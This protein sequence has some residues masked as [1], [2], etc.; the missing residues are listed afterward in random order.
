MRRE[1]VA[2]AITLGA[3]LLATSA[4]AQDAERAEAVRWARAGDLDRAIARLRELRV[5]YP[6]NVS[7]AAD[8][9][10]VLQWAGRDREMLEVFDTIAPETAP[11]YALFAAARAARSLGE[12]ERAETYLG[13]GAE[14]FPDQNRWVV[15]RALVYADGARF[16]DAREVLTASYGTDPEDLEALL[17]W[18]YVSAASRN[19]PAALRYYTEV[20]KRQPEN[21]EALRG[22]IMA[23]EALGAPLRAE[24]LVRDSPGLLEP[25]ER[26]RVAETRSAMLLRWGKLPTGDPRTRYDATDRA[27]EDLE[28]RIA[29]L[30][31]GPATAALS[32][33]RFD[34]LVA[35]RE[36]SRMRDA[37]LLYERLRREG[38]TVPAY[39]RLSAASAYLYLED[40]GAARDL[41]Q[42]VVDEDPRDTEVRFEA[43]LGLFYAWVELE[44]HDRAYEVIDTLDREQPRFT[45]YL[46]TGATIE[47]ESKSTTAVAAALARSYAG[48]LAEAW[49]RLS[50]LAAAA[51]AA[52]WLQSDLASVARARGWPRRSLA[53]IEPWIRTEPDNA[54]LKLGV[55]ESLV[56]LRRYAEA[57]AA[58]DELS[59][60]YPENKGVQ[61]LKT[62]WDVHQMAE[63][64]TRVE[65][66]VGAEP[67][68]PGAGV[69]VATRIWSPPL[70]DYWRVSA[71]Y[72]YATE[73][74]EEGRETFHRVAAG[75][76]Y[77]GPGLRAL[78]ELTYNESTEDGFGGRGE[79][80]WTPTDQISLF[81]VGEI[82]SL[83]TPMRAL[84]NG[85][86]ANALELGG[87]YRFD[88]SR[89]A[90]LSW[91]LMD[92][93]DGNV[94][95][96]LFPRFGQRV[97][98]RPLFTLTATAE[99]YV[100]TNSKTDVAY[101]SPEWL[102]SP[103]VAFIAEH[104]AW[105][106]YRW[107]FV[108]ALTGT[109][110]GT[111]QSGFTGAPIGIVAYEHRWR[112]GPR[113]DLSYGVLFGS[114]VFDGDRE[115]QWLGFTELSVRF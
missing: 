35:Y 73:N 16:E 51:P 25:A 76:E 55:A 23:L 4:H 97:L 83:A 57:G 36:R 27:I 61:S 47:N 75:I 5:A 77:R 106:R 94:R 100:T 67:T 39:A 103:T 110:G 6:Q 60:L 114:R 38:V 93:S 9:A 111:F 65:P 20:L 101:F 21:R 86:R 14:R 10:V 113:V 79:I 91:R 41:Y 81:G 71:G 3:L 112:F 69:A 19:A 13:R 7:I 34:L 49:D 82:F 74:V 29:E 99:L 12:L 104:V 108:H 40:P 96:E 50:P 37:V 88:E 45:R 80:E 54:D 92:F 107:S 30:E 63:W 11:D 68:V 32:R 58:I 2:V 89:A 72:R 56:D 105:R 46:D 1:Q 102:L 62:D 98:D 42:S 31:A 17:A 78:A 90:R 66:S 18:A 84:K 22:R 8:L 115:Q 28:R 52:S 43:R 26:D 70:W 33:A 64:V 85:V 15:L 59:R 95:N 48:Q 109:V 24:E 87:A 53:L 44:R